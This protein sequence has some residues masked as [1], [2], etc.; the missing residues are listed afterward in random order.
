MKSINKSLTMKAT[1]ILGEWKDYKLMHRLYTTNQD[2][3]ILCSKQNIALYYLSRTKF[4]LMSGRKKEREDAT[5]EQ[6]G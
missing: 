5:N 2:S 4:S 3:D 1:S 6:D